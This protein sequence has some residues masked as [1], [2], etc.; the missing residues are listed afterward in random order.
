[1]IL[2][3]PDPEL[4]AQISTYDLCQQIF[5]LW[6]SDLDSWLHLYS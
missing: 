3:K 2:E 1:M 6:E 4:K 5:N